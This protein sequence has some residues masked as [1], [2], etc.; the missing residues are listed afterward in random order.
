MCKHLCAAYIAA[1]DDPGS[2]TLPQCMWNNSGHFIF[3][4]LL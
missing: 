1:A 2:G 4:T 3:A